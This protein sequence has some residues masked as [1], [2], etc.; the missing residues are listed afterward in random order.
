MRA[1]P[2]GSTSTWHNQDLNPGPPDLKA[3]CLPL[4][5]DATKVESND[6]LVLTDPLTH[7]AFVKG[8]FPLQ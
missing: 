4:D 6:T 5:H 8:L 1:F 2:K 7:E 3:K